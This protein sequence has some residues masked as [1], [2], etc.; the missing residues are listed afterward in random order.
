[1]GNLYRTSPHASTLYSEPPCTV[2]ELV[3]LSLEP[4][5]L[6]LKAQQS[7]AMLEEAK[8]ILLQ[9]T[10]VLADKVVEQRVVGF[11]MSKGYQ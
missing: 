7:H 6:V 4:S 9:H 1:M 2:P 10:G 5:L 3:Q 11:F 8:T